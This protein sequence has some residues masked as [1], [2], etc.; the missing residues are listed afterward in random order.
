[1]SASKKGYRPAAFLVNYSRIPHLGAFAAMS[2]TCAALKS[3]LARIAQ[4]I[5]FKLDSSK[6]AGALRQVR[7]APYPAS[8][9]G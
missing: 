8:R 3:A 9:I 6:A 5:R 7:E 2:H 4:K 1:L